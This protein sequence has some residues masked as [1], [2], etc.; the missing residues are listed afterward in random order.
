MNTPIRDEQFYGPDEQSPDHSKYAPKRPRAQQQ[1]PRGDRPYVNSGPMAPNEYQDR[2]MAAEFASRPESVPEPPPLPMED[3]TLGLVGRVTMVVSVAAVVALLAIFAKPI[4][5]GAR[6]LFSDTQ[7]ADAAKPSDR[8]TVNSEVLKPSDRLT[9]N[10]APAKPA[11][12]GP[13]VAI[14]TGEVPPTSAPAQQP[15]ALAAVTPP[16]AQ[17]PRGT[18]FRGVTDTEIRF[19]I[20]APFTGP[21]KELGQNMRLGIETAF[22]AANANGGVF[23]RQLRL[24]AVDDG[25]DPTRTGPAMKQLF[26]KDQVFGLIGNVG[27][28][29]AVVALPYALE[30]KMMFFGAFTGAGL[31][32]SDPPDRYVFNYRASYAEETEAI[33]H[34]LVKVRKLKPRQIAVFAQQDAYGDAG[35]A[36]VAKAFRSIPGGDENAILRLNYQRNTVDVDDAVAQ[37]QKSKIPIKAVIMVPAYRAA[38]KFIEK[39]RDAYPDMTYASVSFVGST[40]LANEL[41]LL[42]RKYASGV[43]VT[44]VVPVVDGHSSLVL[45][46]KTALAKYFPGEAPDYV[47]LEGYVTA[48]IMISALKRN[49][50]QLDTE[51]LVETFENLRGLDLGLGTPVSFGRS[52]HQAVHKVW[53]SQLDDTGHYQSIDLQ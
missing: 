47:S 32:R 29:T 4:A 35:F 41:M 17:E 6:A 44:Q 23:G 36:G 7:T 3:S 5:Q 50:P 46:Y 9:A 15:P 1:P 16:Q 20:A 12:S 10:V 52:E 26:E 51:R 18:P 45:D 13:M 48:S 28:P 30:R 49:G 40:A 37:L 31:L 42:G 14:A 24:V 33:V 43:I 53:G 39:T 27:T 2:R 21:A 8:L 22:R 11:A 25:Y 38:A 34:Y 19:G